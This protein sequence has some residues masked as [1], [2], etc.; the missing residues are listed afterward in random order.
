MHDALIRTEEQFAANVHTAK[1]DPCNYELAKGIDDE[2]P[3]R[4]LL[5]LNLRSRGRGTN[6][7]LN[8]TILLGRNVIE[9]LILPDHDHKAS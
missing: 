6:L 5:K 3:Q 1:S 9:L 7:P 4:G 2:F 8:R